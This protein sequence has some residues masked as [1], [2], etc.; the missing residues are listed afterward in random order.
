M[1]KKSRPD[2][3]LNFRHDNKTDHS[4]NITFQAP[5]NKN[6]KI[7]GFRIFYRI[8][9]KEY[10][11][12][13][14]F[15]RFVN[16]RNHIYNVTIDNLKHYTWYLIKVQT[17]G[18]NYTLCS[19]SLNEIK[20]KTNFKRPGDIENFKTI[21]T[22]PYEFSWTEL[23]ALDDS[24]DLSNPYTFNYYEI[25][26]NNKLTFNTTLNF[27][28]CSESCKISLNQDLFNTF[29]FQAVHL[30]IFKCDEKIVN[31]KNINQN[32]NEKNLD[33]FLESNKNVNVYRYFGNIVSTKLLPID[34]TQGENTK[35][36]VA[37]ITSIILI[38]SFLIWYAMDF[39][40]IKM[41]LHPEFPDEFR[42]LQIGLFLYFSKLNMDNNKHKY[43]F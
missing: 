15:E 4:I 43:I 31:C 36:T 37:M 22:D 42:K 20:V 26:V 17:C 33:N 2:A 34:K 7:D 18:E 8:Q 41:E 23:K 11:E 13:P 32:L 30:Q 6:C 28:K 39:L 40:K 9:G 5:I 3:P 19:A 1:T 25:K 21:N 12:S 14:I 29:T 10:S 38:S 24:E 16:E 27:F 35:A